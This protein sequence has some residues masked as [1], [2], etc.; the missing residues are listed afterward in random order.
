MDELNKKFEEFKRNCGFYFSRVLNWP[1]VPPD[2]L[3]ITLTFRCNLKCKICTIHKHPTS[4]E[5]ELST[6]E[7]LNLVDQAAEMGIKEVVLTGGE[8]FLR[9]DIFDL[10]DHISEKGLISVITTNGTILSEHLAKKIVLSKLNHLHVSIDGLEKTNDSIR[11]S[12]NFKKAIDGIKHIIKIRNNKNSP[13][14]GIA[15][16]ITSQTLEDL[17]HLFKFADDLGVNVINFQPVVKNNM[18]VRD[19]GINNFWIRKEKLKL[20]DKEIDAIKNF[21]AKQIHL[22]RNPNL[23]II[24]SY[25]R[26]K[27]SKSQWK[28]FS[29]F[30][31]AIIA[32]C[33]HKEKAEFHTY[34]CHGLCGNIR[35]KSLKEC[36][37]SREAERLREGTKKCTSPCLQACHSRSESENLSGFSEEFLKS[38]KCEYDA[39]IH[40]K[41]TTLLKKYERLLTSALE[42]AV[43]FNNRHYI[44]ELENAIKETKRVK[45]RFRSIS[46][47]GDNN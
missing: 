23:Q 7:V 17:L 12:G 26:N 36:W 1:L 8:P 16:T 38:L 28:C 19:R 21:K 47:R 5:E 14:V 11:G 20:L 6:E 18:N 33:Q 37:Y 45:R 42:Q 43:F 41:S 35:E 30:K 10:I 13:T 40:Q 32:L 44:C 9:E 4:P 39:K 27:I 31:T 29:G 34:I 22:Y 46:C 2:V 15:C 24:K 25:F 3:Q